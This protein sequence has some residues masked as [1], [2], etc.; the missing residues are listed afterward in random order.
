MLLSAD[1]FADAFSHAGCERLG[2]VEALVRIQKDPRAAL[3]RAGG[4]RRRGRA[5]CLSSGLVSAGLAKGAG[6]GAVHGLAAMAR[7]RLSAKPMLAPWCQELELTAG[8]SRVA[9]AVWR[10]CCSASRRRSKG[11]PPAAG[12]SAAV[13]CRCPPWASACC[14]G[15]HACA[16]GCARVVDG[17]QVLRV[18]RASDAARRDAALDERSHQVPRR[19]VEDAGRLP[20]CCCC[21]SSPLMLA[22]ACASRRSRRAVSSR[23]SRCRSAR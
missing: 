12:E 9:C 10:P 3:L 5:R 7:D 22:C 21:R 4:A 16:C 18:G 17:R 1:S 20:T 13:G 23:R 2:L 19:R 6:C 14:F 15:T 8:G 11:P